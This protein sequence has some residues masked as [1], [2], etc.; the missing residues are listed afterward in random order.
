MKDSEIPGAITPWLA[1]NQLLSADE[2]FTIQSSQKQLLL[3]PKN[4]T[5]LSALLY[6][7]QEE[8]QSFAIIGRGATQPS[9][10]LLIST[11]AF[12]QI[13]LIE[14]E[15]VMIEAGCDLRTLQAELFSM[16]V[17]VGLEDQFGL[18]NRR[19][20]GSILLKGM[21][22]GL[23]LREKPVKERL[24]GV[25]L[26]KKE[27]GIIKLGRE[28]L[29]ASAGPA[30]HQTIWGMQAIDAILTKAYFAVSPLPP[31][32]QFLWWTFADRVHLQDHVR[33]LQQFTSSWERLEII[34]PSCQKEKGFVLAQLS[35]LEEE[36]EAFNQR[37]PAIKE[38]QKGDRREELW[39]FLSEQGYCFH[40]NSTR[41]ELTSTASNGY[42]WEQPL[43]KQ[44]WL[45]K[46]MTDKTDKQEAL[47]FWKQ[48]LMACLRNEEI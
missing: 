10:S 8:K 26:V 44:Q 25:E 14:N 22:S 9:D 32:R 17:E 45:A 28:Y 20:V 19:S 15:I 40:L 11:R 43:A 13:Q 48:H 31:V 42:V 36:M 23:R 1:I 29:A 38:A 24:L 39:R 35:G 34:L 12:N 5:R 46:K 7:L 27:G 37:C 6:A 18:V 16:K 3:A 21:D 41:Q 33:L 30:L 47:P 4:V 2:R